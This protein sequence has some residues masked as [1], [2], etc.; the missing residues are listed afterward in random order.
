M[1]RL[2]IVGDSRGRARE[3]A[4]FPAGS[5]HADFQLLAAAL[6][7]KP[8]QQTLIDVNLDDFAKLLTLKN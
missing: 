4:R 6:K 5:L 7:T 3:W 8:E 1:Y 2:L